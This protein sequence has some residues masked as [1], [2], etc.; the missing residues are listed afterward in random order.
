MSYILPVE[1]EQKYPEDETTYFPKITSMFTMEHAMKIV[2][3]KAKEVHGVN[4]YEMEKLEEIKMDSY[5]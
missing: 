5:D 1:P 4:P 3:E 2:G